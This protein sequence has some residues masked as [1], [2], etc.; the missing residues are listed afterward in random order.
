MGKALVRCLRFRLRANIY[1]RNPTKIS[2]SVVHCVKYHHE[3]VRAYA[4]NHTKYAFQSRLEGVAM[5]FNGGKDAT[6]M[7]QEQKMLTSVEFTITF[8][9]TYLHLL[10][11]SNSSP[12]ASSGW[13]DTK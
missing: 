2:Y 11:P 5:S 3:C 6:G 4:G 10:V 9:L 13:K 12:S 1:V 8:V 7:G